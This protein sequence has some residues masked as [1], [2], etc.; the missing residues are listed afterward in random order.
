MKVF[1][2]LVLVALLLTAYG[3]YQSG[4]IQTAFKTIGYITGGILGVILSVQVLSYYSE[5]RFKLITAIIL[6]F[7]LATIGEFISGKVSLIFRKILFIPPLK[8]IDSLLGAALSV[9]RTLFIIYILS[10]IFL[11][12]PINIS[13]K[14]L[15]DSKF[16][17]YADP[18]IAKTFNHLHSKVYQ[19]FEGNKIEQK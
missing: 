10:I 19:S 15:S 16:Y 14:Y 8:F 11:T 7:L 12:A 1:D 6:I 2:L 5:V 17:T 18:Y 3:G 4:L 9:T 13:D